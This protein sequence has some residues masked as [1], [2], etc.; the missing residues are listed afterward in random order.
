MQYCRP[1]GGGGHGGGDGG[2]NGVSGY[3][4]PKVVLGFGAQ[5][6]LRDFLT[7]IAGNA[8]LQRL[9]CELRDAINIHTH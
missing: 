3:Q 2:G 9:Y 1:D 6:M 7:L 8:K 4:R 5:E